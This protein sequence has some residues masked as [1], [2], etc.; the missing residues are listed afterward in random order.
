LTPWLST[1]YILVDP[2]FG[3]P[4]ASPTWETRTPDF[5]GEATLLWVILNK[6]VEETPKK[7]GVL[8]QVGAHRV[9]RPIQGCLPIL[10]EGGI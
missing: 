3:S 2:P 5:F 10:R 9:G 6:D 4:I 1:R 8:D 7:Q